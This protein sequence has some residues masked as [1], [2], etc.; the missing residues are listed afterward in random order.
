MSR[1]SVGEGT[2]FRSTSSAR[3]ERLSLERLEDRARQLARS[4]EVDRTGRRHPR[5][6]T[7]AF[8]ADIRALQSPPADGARV[9]TG[10]SGIGT[11]GV[12][13]DSVH[14]GWAAPVPSAS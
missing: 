8:D 9:L 10:P 4:Y 12:H 3:P 11:A 5:N 1:A 13:I 6:L 14:S 7:R 2:R